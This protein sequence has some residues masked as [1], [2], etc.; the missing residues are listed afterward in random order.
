V[1]NLNESGVI[2]TSFSDAYQ[3]AHGWYGEVNK[4][5]C[6]NNE[7]DWVGGKFSLINN[8]PYD[9]LVRYLPLRGQAFLPCIWH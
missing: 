4:I 8:S 2:N 7:I 6:S 5:L 1:L 9:S 3:D